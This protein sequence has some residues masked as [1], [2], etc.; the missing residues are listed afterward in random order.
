MGGEG[1][2]IAGVT[3][4]WPFSNATWNETGRLMDVF[5]GYPLRRIVARFRRID[6]KH[7]SSTKY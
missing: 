4:E 1:R 7:R 6:P 3:R 5:W 2:R